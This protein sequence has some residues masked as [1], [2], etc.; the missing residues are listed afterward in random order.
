M[1]GYYLGSQHDAGPKNE[2][3]I[4]KIKMNDP[5]GAGD[6]AHINGSVE[7][8]NNEVSIWGTGV[9]ND[10]MSKIKPGQYVR[11]QWLGKRDPKNPEGNQ[12]HDWDILVDPEVEPLAMDAGF[13]A[14]APAPAPATAEQEAAPE[15]TE[16]GTPAPA[17]D[18]GDDDD[19]DL[20]F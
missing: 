4:H 1:D 5:S 12:Y 17:A 16:E 3:I 11:V 19:D 18:G 7:D 9:L 8:S 2:S 14:S 6:P 20:P 15:T 10:L 13:K